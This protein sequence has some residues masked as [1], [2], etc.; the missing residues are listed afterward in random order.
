VNEPFEADTIAAVA[1]PPGR[2]ALGIVRVSGSRS[3]RILAALVPA[4][5]ASLPPPRKAMLV[6]IVHPEGGALIDR[7][8]VTWFPGP[9]SY[10]G[11][12]ALEICVHGGVLAPALVV[13]ACVRAGARPAR[14]GEFTQR[15]YL[16]GKVDLVQAE[17]VRDLVE[18]ESEAGRRAALVQTEGA[19]SRRLSELREGIVQLE[20]L[21]IYHVDFPEED[22][23][24]V[25]LTRIVE[26]AEALAAK[27]RLLLETAPE[28]EL[29]REGALTVLAG[30]PNSGKS[31]LFNALV[32]EE[33]AIVTDRPGTTRDAIE[34]RI[35]LGGFPFRFVDTAGIREETEEVERLGIEVAK[36]YLSRADLVL[37]CVR[38]DA[39][40]GREEENFLAEHSPHRVVVVLRTMVDLE[41][42]GSGWGDGGGV[43]KSPRRPSFPSR[44]CRAAA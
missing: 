4:F 14:P 42:E 2:G 11:E 29:L 27:L 17:G 32:G 24:P 16:N 43:P 35:S 36:R 44:W 39:S 6:R 26:E 31:S 40:W 30:R 8:L 34:A 19:L 25:P 12:D 21:L 38:K 22:E 9:A 18:A 10:T 23:P 3:R 20:A 28:G 33:R 1:T 37:L 13:E 5:A 7:G 41:G 15:A